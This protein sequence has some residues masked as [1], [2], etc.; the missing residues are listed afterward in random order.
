MIRTNKLA[1]LTARRLAQGLAI[2][3]FAF[4]ASANSEK[5]TSEK[6]NFTVETIAQ[7]L[8]IPWGMAAL[9]DG[10]MLITERT[11]TLRLLDANGNLHPDPIQG[12]PA[13]ESSRQGG[14]LDVAIHPDYKNNGWIYLSY[15]SPKT[16]GEPGRGVPILH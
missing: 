7:G 9:P 16:R 8:S 1:G 11:G 2:S 15:S 10:G 6:Q 14:L 3:L 5:I 13:V 12:A 4:N